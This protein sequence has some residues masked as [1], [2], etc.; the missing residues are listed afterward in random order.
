MCCCG[1]VASCPFLTFRVWL[2][3][4]LGPV[5]PPKVRHGGQCKLC[6]PCALPYLACTCFNSAMAEC[7]AA[8][9]ERFSVATAI[10]R[11]CLLRRLGA[12][13]LDQASFAEDYLGATPLG[14]RVA[15]GVH[16]LVFLSSRLSSF[17]SFFVLLRQAEGTL[18]KA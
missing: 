8:L 2:I 1:G 16:R 11:L 13:A 10:P 7:R 3:H 15:G 14:M 4:Q 6:F 5:D 18:W 12:L 17:L 9:P